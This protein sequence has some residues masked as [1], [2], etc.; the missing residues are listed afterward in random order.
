MI[1]NEKLMTPR[2]TILKENEKSIVFVF[3]IKQKDNLRRAKFSYEAE[4]N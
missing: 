2:S 4:I 3:H 1:N